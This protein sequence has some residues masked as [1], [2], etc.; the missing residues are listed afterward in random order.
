MDKLW[1]DTFN[2]FLK[3][4]HEKGGVGGSQINRLLKALIEKPK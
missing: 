4:G 3:I 2:Y 1:P